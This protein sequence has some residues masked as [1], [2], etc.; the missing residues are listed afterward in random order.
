MENKYIEIN[1][2]TLLFWI[3]V[4]VLC[5]VGFS[6]PQEGIS[7]K[8]IDRQVRTT[9]E[10][11]E[12]IFSAGGIEQILVNM[13]LLTEEEARSLTVSSDNMKRTNIK[14]EDF[15]KKIQ[16][17]MTLEWF[18]KYEMWQEDFASYF[19]NENG[20]LAYNDFMATGHVNKVNSISLID[21]ESGLYEAEIVS[22]EEFELETLKINFK[23]E[24]ND[25]N[26]YVIS[27]INYN[28]NNVI[29]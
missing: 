21:E 16:D 18:N 24:K 6:I 8:S 1:V 26:K 22:K 4:I 13:N 28:P 9:L 17:Y 23:V 19:E 27:Y 15:M 11:Y 5:V 29:Y 7:Q 12:S 3:V 20:Y 2:S 25:N 10:N 14:Y